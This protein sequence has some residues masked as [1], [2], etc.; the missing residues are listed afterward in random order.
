MNK[1]MKALLAI[2]MAAVPLGTAAASALPVSE[3]ADV[4]LLFQGRGELYGH[5]LQAFDI[6]DDVAFLCY[7]GGM[8]ATYNMKNGREIAT[9]PLG[10]CIATN[11]CGNANFGEEFPEGNSHFP[12][13][14]VS[15]DLTTKACYVEDV[16]KTGA[17]LI[18]TIWFDIDPSYTGGQ[19]IYDHDRNRLVYMQRRNKDIRDAGNTFMMLEFRIPALNEGSEI[20]FTNEDALATYELPFY[21]PLYQGA[22]VSN[23]V[24]LQTHGYQENALGSWV[25]IMCF[26]AKNH[27]FTR[28]I[29]LTKQVPKE[30]QC[31]TIYNGSMIMDFAGGE[32]F[33]ILPEKGLPE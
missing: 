21:S 3:G 1:I 33:R 12:A 8:C 27:E 19:V 17:R 26:D 20:H 18:Q 6:Y 4:E 25:G 5:A 11:H 31:I 16:T 10:S 15:G 14:Y 30:P 29:D 7:D 32:V 13:L 9:F 2:T 23:G 24:V 22:S 28:H